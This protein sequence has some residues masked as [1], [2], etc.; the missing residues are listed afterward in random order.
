MQSYPCTSN[1]NVTCTYYAG[2]QGYN[3]VFYNDRIIIRF[4]DNSY[5]TMKFH[6]I[7]PDTC[8]VQTNIYVYYQVGVYDRVTKDFTF[9]Y[10]GY[11]YRNWNYWINTPA[12]TQIAMAGDMLGKAGSYRNNVSITVDYPSP[13]T[14][15]LTFLLL[16]T[17]WSFF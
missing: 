5:K 4:N 2:Q 11:F 16:C 1:I 7:I 12:T 14:G 10:A 3:Q 9:N 6:V 8:T 17:Q 15:G 13:Q